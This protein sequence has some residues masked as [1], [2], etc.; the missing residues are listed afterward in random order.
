M[1]EQDSSVLKQ[2]LAQL[3]SHER[4]LEQAL[5]LADTAAQFVATDGEIL[6]ASHAQLRLLGYKR[7][8]YVGHNLKEFLIESDVVDR[9]ATGAVFEASTARMRRK[10]GSYAE[11]L[12]KGGQAGDGGVTCVTL[13]TDQATRDDRAALRESE[14]RYRA[15]I[16]N[17]SEG[18]WRCELEHP[19]DP[20]ASED[21]QIAQI[22]QWAVL[23]ECNDAMARMYGQESAAAITGARVSDLFVRED[24]ANEQFL[25]AFIRS[26]YQLRDAESHEWGADGQDRYFLNTF[27]G[28][29]EDGLLVRGW[30]TQRDITNQKRTAEALRASEERFA[31]FMTHLPGAAWIKDLEGRYVYAN[32]EAERIFRTDLA[33]LLGKSDF[34]L[35]PAET[36]REFVKNDQR[37]LSQRSGIQLVEILEHADGVHESVVSKFAILDSVG[38]AVGVGGVAIDVTEH[39]RAQTELAQSRERLALATSAAKIGT[40]DWDI[41]SGGLVWNDIEEA[42]FGLD[43]GTFEGRI[44]GW[45]KHVHPEDLPKMQALLEDAMARHVPELEFDFRIIRP[46]GR[47]RWIEGAA[48]FFYGE[49]GEPLRMVGV[50]MDMTERRETESALRRLNRELEE[51]AYV[52]SHD[53]KEPLRTVRAYTELLMRRHVPANEDAA[54]CAEFIATGV[55]RMEALIS[56]LLAYSRTIHDDDD[57][58]NVCELGA[59]LARSLA[60]LEEPIRASG[61]SITTDELPLIHGDEGQL[62]QVFQNL[63]SNSLKYCPPDRRPQI[64]IGATREDGWWQVT[65]ADNGIGFPEQYSE[66]IFG[67]FKRLHKAEYPGTGLGLAICKRI[68]ERHGGRIWANSDPGHGSVFTFTLRAGDSPP[69]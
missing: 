25:R 21:E 42:V 7:E 51:F 43:P 38:K 13:P 10:D 17:S 50:N 8:E 28:V 47:V 69:E 15:F 3:R 32:R 39:R 63:L 64:H 44:E 66:R 59:A 12:V 23:A 52:A 36:A 35:F 6:W 37:A 29:I 55:D 5:T 45:A 30:G 33:D 20:V 31:G 40:F 48:R 61:A 49:H 14:E 24:P 19:I 65:V 2:E 27:V 62:S 11:V 9:L 16:R 53:L 46:D 54:V 1:A 41:P 58:M 68:V 67:L 34:E 4:M 56:D 60:W 26:G 22:Y 18:I 57:A